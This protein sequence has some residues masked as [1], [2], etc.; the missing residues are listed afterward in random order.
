LPNRFRMSAHRP[1]T[2]SPVPSDPE[3]DAKTFGPSPTCCRQSS[4][5]RLEPKNDGIPVLVGLVISQPLGR[6]TIH[7]S[8]HNTGGHSGTLVRC[9]NVVPIA[10]SRNETVRAISRDDSHVLDS[11]TSVGKRAPRRVRSRVV[12]DYITGFWHH[13]RTDGNKSVVI[14][15]DCKYGR[16]IGKSRLWPSRGIRTI[17]RQSVEIAWRLGSLT[18]DHVHEFT[19]PFAAWEECLA[20]EPRA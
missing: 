1:P 6:S 2:A 11:S 3:S 4:V 15:G 18:E 19:A 17:S 8:A 20:H 12:R 5:D 7:G 14:P 10:L 9:N 16:W 13:S